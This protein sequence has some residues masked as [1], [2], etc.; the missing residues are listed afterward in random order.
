MGQAP[1]QQPCRQSQKSWRDPGTCNENVLQRRKRPQPAPQTV[2]QSPGHISH[3]S[4]LSNEVSGTRCLLRQLLEEGTG[5]SE[6]L[7][8]GVGWGGCTQARKVM[9]LTWKWNEILKPRSVCSEA[10]SGIII[11]SERG[12]LRSHGRFQRGVGPGEEAR[13]EQT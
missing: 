8:G 9:D 11:V 13:A 6:P 2:Q 5:I 7:W 1:I 10:S 3:L 12:R 4:A